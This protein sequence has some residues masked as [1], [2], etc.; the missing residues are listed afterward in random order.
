[1][2]NLTDVGLISV[3]KPDNYVCELQ[4]HTSSAQ[5]LTSIFKFAV[6]RDRNSY[7]TFF[8]LV[9]RYFTVALLV[10]WAACS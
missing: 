6:L 2:V 9:G 1:M 3:F 5:V 7:A 8:V 4:N 10:R